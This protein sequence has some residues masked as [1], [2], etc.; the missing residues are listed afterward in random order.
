MARGLG[1]RKEFWKFIFRLGF[2]VD[3]LLYVVCRRIFVSSRLFVVYLRT[4]F[5]SLLISSFCRCAP[6]CI[7]PVSVSHRTQ[8][9][10]DFYKFPRKLLQVFP[11]ICRNLS[12]EYAQN[13]TL[14][15]TIKKNVCIEER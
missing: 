2:A 4:P 10:C 7:S 11:K 9:S 14:N 8:N 5:Y 13:L 15:R 3:V 1:G 12:A 6:F